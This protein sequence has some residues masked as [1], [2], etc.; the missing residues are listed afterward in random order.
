[1]AE[2]YHLGIPTSAVPRFA[3]LLDP[4][5]PS[6]PVVTAIK[7]KPLASRREYVSHSGGWNGHEVLVI[8][9]GIGAPPLAI[10]VEE[11]ARSGTRAFVLLGTGAFHDDVRSPWLL[12]HGAARGDGTSAQYAPLQFPALPDPV[13][14]ARLASA[15]GGAAS[16]GVVET[17]DVLEGCPMTPGLAA[18]R[19]LRCAALF[20]AAAARGVHA[21]AL[22]VD[23]NGDEAV[24]GVVRQQVVGDMAVA[25]YRSLTSIERG[26]SRAHD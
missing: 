25:A 13:L 21:A 15:T 18:A 17:V 8:T 14:R 1:M 7:G 9:V 11:L 4:L 23:P 20:V 19:D 10:A 12:P 22:L 16:Y 2:L 3:V 26:E 6:E 5:L 24:D